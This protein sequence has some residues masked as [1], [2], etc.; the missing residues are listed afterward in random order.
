MPLVSICMPAYNAARYIEEA[1]D[2]VFRQSYQNIEVIVV[3][4]GSTDRTADILAKMQHPALQVF[5]TANNGQCAAA[6]LAYAKSTGQLIKFM[7]ADDIISDNFLE[8]QVKRIGNRNDVIASADW[9]RFYNDDLNTFTLFKDSIKGDTKPIEWLVASFQNDSAMMQCARWLIPKP[10]LQRSGVW[11]ERLSL[12]NDFEFFI[13]VML[14]AAEIRFAEGATLYYRSGVPTSLSALK[15]RKGL[16]SAFHSMDDG[17]SYI[18]AYE[19]SPRTRLV[20]AN[21]YQS[22]I[23]SFYPYQPDLL[24]IAEKRVRELGGATLLCYAGGLTLFFHKIIG[25]KLTRHI[26]LLFRKG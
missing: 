16:E 7:D 24:A 5:H 1:L 14:H 18:L 3:N 22:Y 23:Y 20:A 6:N 25:W 8:S 2:S 11:D 9:G 4:D 13:R 12:I 17:I 15:S 10:V 26:K 19:N 21:S